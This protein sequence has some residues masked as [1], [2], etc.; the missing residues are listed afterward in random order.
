[1]GKLL[2]LVLLLLTG[3]SPQRPARVAAVTIDDLPVV[4]VTSDWWSVTERLLGALREHHVPAVGFVNEAKLYRNG[5]LDSSR[6]ALLSTWLR[7]E[8]PP[9]SLAAP[10]S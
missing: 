6:V 7:I 9:R 2:P 10:D 4:S 3:A 5:M 8:A 1:M